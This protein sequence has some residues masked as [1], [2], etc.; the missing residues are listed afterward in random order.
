[1]FP[2]AT[3]GKEELC[4]PMHV[5]KKKQNTIPVATWDDLEAL[6]TFIYQT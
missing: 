4:G 5:N 2:F 1:M 6:L 3:S